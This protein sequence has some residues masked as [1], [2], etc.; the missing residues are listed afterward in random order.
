MATKEQELIESLMSDITGDKEYEAHEI[1]KT[2][3]NILAQYN[4]STDMSFIEKIAS[5][6]FG[7]KGEKFDLGDLPN[8]LQNA[9]F[10]PVNTIADIA[11]RQD[12]DMIIS[13]IPEMY[14]VIQVLRD[15][16]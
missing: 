4:L 8:E 5:M 10:L 13:Q 1:T 14:K 3:Q 9:A 6:K 12:L 11:L 2:I 7:E 16:T 15:A